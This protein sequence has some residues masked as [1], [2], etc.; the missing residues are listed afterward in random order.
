[1]LSASYVLM[2]MLP[3]YGNYQVI[4]AE[5]Y[6]SFRKC[7][8]QAQDYNYKTKRKSF[9]VCMPIVKDENKIIRK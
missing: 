1:M 6:L 4:A 7:M 3:V 9:A 2:I 8:V 5:S